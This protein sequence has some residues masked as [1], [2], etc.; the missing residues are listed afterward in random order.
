MMI[1]IHLGTILAEWFPI[2]KVSEKDVFYFPI[3]LIG[4]QI[5]SSHVKLGSEEGGVKS[6]EEISINTLVLTG[7]CNDLK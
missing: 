5:A 7:S 2:A 1:N 6:V 4:T 3:C